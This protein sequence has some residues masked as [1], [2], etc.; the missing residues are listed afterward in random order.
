M[1]DLTISKGDLGKTVNVNKGDSFVV[2]LAEN[3]ATGYRWEVSLINS[4]ITELQSSSFSR[5]S[6]SS[7][8]GGG[9]RT[10]IFKAKSQGLTD[11]GLVL[12]R[13]WEPKTSSIDS[14]SVTI[15]VK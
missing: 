6:G 7:L 11:L 9:T 14:F 15:Q 2:S 3:P 10:F 8:G 13:E 1:G 5:G 4:Q 12:R